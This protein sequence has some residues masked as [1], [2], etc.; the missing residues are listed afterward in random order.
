MPATTNKQTVLSHVQASLKKKFTCPPPPETPRAVLEEVIYAILRE[1]VPPQQADSAYTKFKS[2]FIDW[3]EVR[4]SSVQEVTDALAELPD[5]GNKA[6]RITDFLQEHFERTYSFQLDDL[7][8]KGLKQAQKQLGRYKDHG[9]SDFVVAWVSQRTL[10]GHAVPL[11]EPSLRVL[12]RLGILEE[13]IEDLESA[14]GTIE[15]YVSKAN[16]PEFTDRLI[17]LATAICTPVNPNCGSCPLKPD[18]PTGQA[19]TA[20]KTKSKATKPR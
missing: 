5:S 13:E 16:G 11:D 2:E 8:K 19:L 17:Q 10:A 18:C 6:K 4:V 9:V 12:T 14:R 20:P 7:E 1:G 15:H 3:N